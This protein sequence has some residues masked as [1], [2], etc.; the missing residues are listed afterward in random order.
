MKSDPA[1]GS[2][3]TAVD[4]AV[5]TKL[6]W[7]RDDRN[8]NVL[9]TGAPRVGKTKLAKTLE[10]ERGYAIV[11]TD[12]VRRFFWELEDHDLRVETQHAVYRHLL[13]TFPCNLVVEGDGL[14]GDRPRHGRSTDDLELATRLHHEGLSKTFIIGCSDEAWTHKLGAIQTHARD[15]QCWTHKLPEERLVGLAQNIIVRSQALKALAAV[16]NLNYIEI[17]TSDFSAALH[18]AVRL[19]E[20]ECCSDAS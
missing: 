18:R 4:H 15:N 7:H 10:R 6:Q 9:I 14:T 20:Q 5:R 2:I 8:G 3:V 17:N 19:I 1:V 16:R 13:E 11:S 12:F